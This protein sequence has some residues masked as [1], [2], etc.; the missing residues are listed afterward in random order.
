MFD[1]EP[2]GI[3]LCAKCGVVLCELI[4]LLEKDLVL[5]IFRVDLV[6]KSGYKL[7][8]QPILIL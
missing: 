2:E 1:F 4:V 3:D 8:Q 7:K 5:S 6:L